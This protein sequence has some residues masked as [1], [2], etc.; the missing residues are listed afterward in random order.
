MLIFRTDHVLATEHAHCVG[1]VSVMS[2]FTLCGHVGADVA[3]CVC[4]CVCVCVCSLQPSTCPNHL[5]VWKLLDQMRMD[6]GR[7][8]KQ[9]LQSG[10]ESL[11]S[12][13]ESQYI[14]LLMPVFVLWRC[15][16]E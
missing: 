5:P 8:C 3:M 13:L 9:Q 7:Q 12:D 2:V 14:S 15:L 4:V 16:S 11:E 1:G 10:T 6:P